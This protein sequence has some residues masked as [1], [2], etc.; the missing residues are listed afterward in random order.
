[1]NQDIIARIVAQLKKRTED[2]Q[3]VDEEIGTGHCKACG[4]EICDLCYDLQE[5]ES[6]ITLLEA[7]VEN[8]LAALELIVARLER[9]VC[10][11][12]GR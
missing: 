4:D 8:R 10:T 6:L 11:N 7:S 3:A 12:T 2:I 5:C 1:M 9:C